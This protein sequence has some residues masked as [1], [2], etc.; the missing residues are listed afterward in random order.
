VNIIELSLSLRFKV[1]IFHKNLFAIGSNPVEGSSKNPIFGEPIRELAT[2]S[3]LLF[4]PLRLIALF[5]YASNY[6]A[7]K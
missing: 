7:F 6:K 2:H 1:K 4:P 5:S 3:F